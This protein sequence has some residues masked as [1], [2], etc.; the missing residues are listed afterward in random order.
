MYQH[1][2]DITSVYITELPGEGRAGHQ[3]DICMGGW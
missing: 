2:Q 3:R 1:Q